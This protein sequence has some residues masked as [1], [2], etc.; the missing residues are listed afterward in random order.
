M[1]QLQIKRFYY[2]SGQIHVEAK[3]LD[4]RIH[5]FYRT[6][7]FNGQ[8]AEE[9]FYRK[10]VLHGICRQWDEKGHL[11]G[12]FEMTRGTGT[13]RYWHD[14]GRL[15]MEIDSLNGLFH[16][17][18]RLWLR[19]GTLIKETFHLQD[20]AVS[21][22][23]YLKAARKN[24]DWPQ[25]SGQ[26][27]GKIKRRTLALEQRQHELFIQSILEKSHAEAEEWLE[28]A[29]GSRQRSLAKFA[30]RRTALRFVDELYSAAANTVFVAPIY[31]PSKAKLFAD[32]MLVQLPKEQ[33]KR[34]RLRRICQRLCDR[35]HGALLP[36]RGIGESHLFLRLA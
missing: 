25:Y 29:K 22:A 11:L 24:P 13:Q 32:W 36:D 16:G 3:E 28:G 18:T 33:S 26:S 12:A 20:K 34:R 8:L 15:K 10:G 21:R 35:R 5:G 19:D 30:T 1:P 14:N 6:W 31:G 9:L 7:H 17:R 27:A 2:R 4:G 23:A